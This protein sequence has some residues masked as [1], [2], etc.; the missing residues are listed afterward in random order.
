MY[1]LC[2]ARYPGDSSR[3]RYLV[4]NYHCVEL[5]LFDASLKEKTKVLTLMVPVLSIR[6]RIGEKVPLW[7]RPQF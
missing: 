7:S 3:G 2:P 5:P 6:V 1:P 4:G